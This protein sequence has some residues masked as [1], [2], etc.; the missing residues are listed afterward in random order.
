ML[1]K[2]NLLEACSIEWL[3][4]GWFEDGIEEGKLI[5]GSCLL[6]LSSIWA[7]SNQS[8]GFVCRLSEK[9]IAWS[10]S[11]SNCCMRILL[12]KAICTNCLAGS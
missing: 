3:F 10:K 2:V 8:W 11:V 9:A 5:Q 6:E 4:R 1:V 7:E 12:M